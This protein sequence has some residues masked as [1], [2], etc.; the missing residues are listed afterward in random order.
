LEGAFPN[1]WARL[2]FAGLAVDSGSGEAPPTS[3]DREGSKPIV[4]SAPEKYE[5]Q[6]LDYLDANPEMRDWIPR[7]LEEFCELVSI[8]NAPFKG[9]IWEPNI[10]AND[11]WTDAVLRLWWDTPTDPS[12]LDLVWAAGL[13]VAAG[14]SLWDRKRACTTWTALGPEE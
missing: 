2:A 1:G 10:A 14:P 6:I 5:K 3:S 11:A 13:T 9:G 7:W 4:P 12:S 8:P